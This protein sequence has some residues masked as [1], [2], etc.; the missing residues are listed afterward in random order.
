MH[1]SP[2]SSQSQEIERLQKRHFDVFS[3]TSVIPRFHDQAII[4][5]ASSKRQANMKHV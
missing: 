1:A 2:T 3:V 5:Q 4:E